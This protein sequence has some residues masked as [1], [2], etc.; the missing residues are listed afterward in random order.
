[1][2]IHGPI[3]PEKWQKQLV[4]SRLE[5]YPSVEVVI[6]SVVNAASI[7]GM[8]L[9]T[10]AVVTDLPTTPPPTPAG[11]PSERTSLETGKDD[12]HLRKPMKVMFLIDFSLFFIIFH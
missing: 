3:T 6:N 8:V 1:M 12:E 9:T 11:G 5:L 10:D 2:K 7:A 4:D